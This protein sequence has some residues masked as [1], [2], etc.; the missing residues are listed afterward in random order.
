VN[1][2]LK[3]VVR[4]ICTLRSVGV[5]APIGWPPLPGGTVKRRPLPDCAKFFIIILEILAEQEISL[6]KAFLDIF[7]RDLQTPNIQTLIVLAH[8]LDT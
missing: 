3:S 4:E 2:I 6:A 1:Q 5:G 7:Y 8:I